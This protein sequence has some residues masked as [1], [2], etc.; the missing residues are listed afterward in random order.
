[1]LPSLNLETSFLP[2]SLWLLR[3]YPLVWRSSDSLEWYE[4][5]SISNRLQPNPPLTLL[6]PFD[7]AIPFSASLSGYR[8]SKGLTAQ[9][10]DLLPWDASDQCIDQNFN[11]VPAKDTLLWDCKNLGSLT[12]Y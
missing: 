5:E 7:Q 8:Q 12:T 6:L 4:P 10:E 1:M 9:D 11:I 3:P 2:N